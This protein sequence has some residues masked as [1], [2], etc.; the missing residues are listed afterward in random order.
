MNIS[1]TRGYNMAFGVLTGKILEG[2]YPDILEVTVSNVVPK[3]N[4]SDEAETRKQAVI[5][6]VS[7]CE[8]IGV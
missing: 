3:G 4:D 7:M 1:I 2:L 8:T 6:L 5:S